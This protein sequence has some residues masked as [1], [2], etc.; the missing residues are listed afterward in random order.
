MGEN[1]PTIAFLVLTSSRASNALETATFDPVDGLYTYNQTSPLGHGGGLR[2][3]YRFGLYSHCAFISNITQGRCSNGTAGAKYQPYDA[4][5]SDMPSRYAN[6]TNLV[7]PESASAFRNDG[8][9]GTYTT[10][11]YWLILLATIAVALAFL[12]Y[13]TLSTTCW[14]RLIHHSGV[15]TRTYT[16]LLST[17]F[18]I[19][20]TV[21][22]LIAAAM[23]TAMVNMSA[24]VN[25]F[26]IQAQASTPLGIVV[27]AGPGLY[28]LWAAFACL[29]ASIVPYMIRYSLSSNVRRHVLTEST[30]AALTEV[31]IICLLF[32][33]PSRDTS[34]FAPFVLDC[35]AH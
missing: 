7:L 8:T 3:D 18:A 19:L 35:S 31:D 32:L 27:H 29:F 11:A 14:H 21:L 25:A 20:G 22:L 10:A 28:I 2:D 34:P 4:I 15:C 1:L 23:W 9:L 6:I 30:A 12:L 5:T 17:S 33:Y 26:V 24:D 13:A 16:F